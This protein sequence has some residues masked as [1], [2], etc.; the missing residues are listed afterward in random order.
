MQSETKFKVGD[1][2]FY[3]NKPFCIITSNSIRI[4]IKSLDQIFSIR[5]S[6]LDELTKI[7]IGDQL[8]INKDIKNHS[9]W[10]FYEKWAKENITNKTVIEV[11]T[12]SI[13]NDF[14]VKLTHIHTLEKVSN[15]QYLSFLIQHLKGIEF[16]VVQFETKDGLNGY[17][18]GRGL[19]PL[20]YILPCAQTEAKLECVCPTLDLMRWGHNKGCYLH[21][22]SSR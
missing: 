22:E 3:D 21:K 19:V 1:I 14:P 18:N 8:L 11:I 20:Q 10:E 7:N 6:Q 16:P 9:L 5:T 15:D 17:I 2:V 13:D 4:G 12:H